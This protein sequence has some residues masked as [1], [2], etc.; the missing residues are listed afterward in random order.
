[1]LCDRYKE[2]QN[3]LC[4]DHVVTSLKTAFFKILQDYPSHINVTP[5]TSAF[6]IKYPNNISRGIQIIYSLITGLSMVPDDFKI[7]VTTHFLST[8]LR[9]N[10]RYTFALLG[11]GL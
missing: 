8:S 10:E 5:S 9:I 6:S 3:T 1:M 2:K 7:P 4:G 11:L